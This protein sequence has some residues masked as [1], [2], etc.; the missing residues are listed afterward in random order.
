M[1]YTPVNYEKCSSPLRNLKKENLEH[2]AMYPGEAK[3]GERQS[4]MPNDNFC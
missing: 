2:V 4:C 3:I 1:I